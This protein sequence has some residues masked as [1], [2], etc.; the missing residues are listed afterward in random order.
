MTC[1]GE[2]IMNNIHFVGILAVLGMTSIGLTSA[3]SYGQAGVSNFEFDIPVNNYDLGNSCTEEDVI[4]NGNIHFSGHVTENGN[5]FI[6]HLNVRFDGVTGTGEQSDN[7]YKLLGN[8]NFN[9]KFGHG[10]EMIQ[11][12]GNIKL[13]SQ[14]SPD[15]A[16]FDYSFKLHTNANG[17]LINPSFDFGPLK[18]VG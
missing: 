10:A 8:N 4:L 5:N 1:T 12:N 15:N 14:G 3:S 2:F 7:S 11:G 17:D 18:C 6:A 9:L 16:K 13:I